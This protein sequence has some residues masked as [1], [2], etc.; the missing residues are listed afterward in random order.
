M[1]FYKKKRFTFI[2]FSQLITKQLLSELFH[3]IF[4]RIFR[5]TSRN[6]WTEIILRTYYERIKSQV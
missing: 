3:E 6:T 5:K 1:E 4:D 2:L